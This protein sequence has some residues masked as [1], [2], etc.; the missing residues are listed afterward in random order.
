MVE[1]FDGEGEGVVRGGLAAGEEHEIVG[2]ANHADSGRGETI[3]KRVEAEVGE[4]WGDDCALRNAEDGA[5]EMEAIPGGV[6]EPEMT[7]ADGGFV[8]D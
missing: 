3:V 1:R 2:V 8:W 6:I 7:E 5:G 4:H